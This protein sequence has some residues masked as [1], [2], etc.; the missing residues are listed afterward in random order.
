MYGVRELDS[1]VKTAKKLNLKDVELGYGLC[2]T[3][4]KVQ[5]TKLEIED[6]EEIED[7]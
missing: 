5:E 1:L 3:D 6:I 7:D 4:D 2:Y